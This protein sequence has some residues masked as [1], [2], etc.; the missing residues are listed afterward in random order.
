MR[1]AVEEALS[2]NKIV[3]VSGHVVGKEVFPKAPL[4]TRAIRWQSGSGMRADEIQDLIEAKDSMDKQRKVSPLSPAEDAI[5]IDTFNSSP[6]RVT[7]KIAQHL[8]TEPL[9][10]R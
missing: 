2:R 8:T 1:Q 7:Q 5:L 6:E 4:K 3:V 9:C 10:Q